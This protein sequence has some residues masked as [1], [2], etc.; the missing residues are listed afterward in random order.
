M[1]TRNIA[2]V[3]FAV[4]L[5]QVGMSQWTEIQSLKREI[6]LIEAAKDILEDQSR[7]LAA[8][9]TRL[10]SE[11]EAAA[12]RNFVLGVMS[13]NKKPNEYDSVWHDG[14]N[15]GMQ[16]QQQYTSKEESAE[17]APPR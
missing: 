14:Y 1:N 17:P 13:A 10:T 9:V 8:S 6:G 5:L 11:S 15:R 7:D 2:A 16:V 12:T 3:I 4:A